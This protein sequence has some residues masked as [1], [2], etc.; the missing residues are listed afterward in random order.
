MYKDFLKSKTVNNENRHDFATE[1]L[2]ITYRQM[3]TIK[4][5][6]Q[7]FDLRAIYQRQNIH[8]HMYAHI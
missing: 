7:S 4:I 6:E 5:A 1:N 3:I 8:T 2:K